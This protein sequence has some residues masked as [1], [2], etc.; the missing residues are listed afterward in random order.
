MRR[1]VVYFSL[2]LVIGAFFGYLALKD[3]NF[4]AVSAYW[5]AADKLQLVA[6]S[7]AFMAMYAVC[8]GARVVRWNELV[9]P[10]ASVDRRVVTEVAVVGFAAIVL[11]PLRLGEFVRPILLARRT[12][13]PISGGLGTAVVERVVD[14]LTITGLLFLTL[15]TYRG[16]NPTTS[17]KAIGAISAAIFIPALLI[18]LLAWWR[19]DHAAK[20]LELTVGRF[21][22]KIAAKLEGMLFAFIDGLRALTR[23]HALTRFMLYSSVYWAFNGLSMWVLA[24][25]GFGLEVGP[26]DA[27]TMLA[28]LVVGIMIPAG[29]AMAGNFQ[30]FLLQGLGLFVVLDDHTMGATTVFAAALHILQF[31][32]IVLPAVVVM[33]QNPQSRNL[34]QLANAQQTPDAH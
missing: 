30:Y 20:L 11:L 26:W 12:H 5:A 34:L 33:V 24:R 16:D 25:Y 21:V 8:H 13:I 2:A 28:I 10:I 1:L 23:A 9:Q 27:M 14:G 3:V 22:P 32:V 4:D 17:L 31:I 7:I 6:V 18:C 15:A 29:P 19:R